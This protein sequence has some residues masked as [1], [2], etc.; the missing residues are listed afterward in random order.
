MP[1][2]SR[3]TPIATAAPVESFASW[4]EKN[5]GGI[6]GTGSALTS[7]AGGISSILVGY[8][9]ARE[10]EKQAQEEA[11][12]IRRAGNR[13]LGAQTV[14]Y[15]H[16]GV[17]QA[18]TPGDVRADSIAEIERE[19]SNSMQKFENAANNKRSEGI[20]GL[21]AGMSDAA[22]T[23]ALTAKGKGG[24]AALFGRN[25]RVGLTSGLLSS[26]STPKGP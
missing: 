16:A 18:G 20:Q 21:T 19:V 3:T 23:T 17:T 6:L 10:L 9:Q 22:L 2:L 12:R 5:S 4:W 14:A 24:T 26:S 7:L 25:S 13:V 8:R 1:G 15:A 11:K